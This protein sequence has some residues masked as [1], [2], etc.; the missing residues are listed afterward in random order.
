M[1]P[2]SERPTE[3]PEE[4]ALR[5]SAEPAEQAAPYRRGATVRRV[6][7][8]TPEDLQRIAER[9]ARHAEED[10]AAT[11]VAANPPRRR[12]SPLAVA[13]IITAVL[14]PY[15]GLILAIIG[16]ARLGR[17]SPTSGRW[18]CVIAI[19]VSLIE[20]WLFALLL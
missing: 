14:L 13:A 11:D 10:R 5:R 8:L 12:L 6:E 3:W 20:I 16:T 15:L 2:V 1:A 9:R 7:E 19:V 18:L 4:R 17:Q